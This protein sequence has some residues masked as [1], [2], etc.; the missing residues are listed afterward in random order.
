MLDRWEGAAVIASGEVIPRNALKGLPLHKVDLRLTKEIRLVGTAKVQLIGEVFNLFNRANY[1]SYNTALSATNAAQT[2]L[3]RQARAKHRQRLC[4]G[5]H[6]SDSDSCSSRARRSR[7]YSRCS[8][9]RGR[10]AE[11]S[12]S[13]RH[14]PRPLARGLRQRGLESQNRFPAAR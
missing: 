12:R 11:E 9:G 10:R 4:Q 1:G 2:A 13:A 7:R 8:V 6:S 5:R 14:R 3:L